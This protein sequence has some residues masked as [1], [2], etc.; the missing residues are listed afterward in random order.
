MK[1]VIATHNQDKVKE[2]RHILS[3]L[4][5]EVLTLDEFGT[6]PDTVED[7]KTLEENALKK[8]REVRSFTG[9]SALADDTGL[10]VDA[11][12]GEPGI[13]AARYAGEDATYQDN[14]RKLLDQMRDVPDDKR[15]VQFRTVIAVAL[16]PNDS[17]RVQ[18]FLAAQPEKDFGVRLGREQGVDALV[19]EGIIHGRVSREER[20]N[21]GFGYDPVF[22]VVER[23]CTLAE[24]SAEEKNTMSHR[25]RG[26][27]EMRELFLRLEL[28]KEK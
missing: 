28:I 13:F 10:F 15:S 8:A 1:L 4:D 20:G 18:G 27:I 25:Y 23:G 21:R 2:I 22:E 12:G 7:G 5:A 3:G 19:S 14:T 17:K 26:L 24:M 11:L 9:V 16:A 6:V